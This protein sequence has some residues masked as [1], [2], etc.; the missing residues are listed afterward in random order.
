MKDWC[1]IIEFSGYKILVEIE[2]TDDHTYDIIKTIDLDGARYKHIEHFDDNEDEVTAAY[3]VIDK[4]DAE[5]FFHWAW[6]AHKDPNTN[7]GPI[8]LN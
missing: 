8:N 5:E 2:W 1:K 4:A 7:D 6:A 3:D